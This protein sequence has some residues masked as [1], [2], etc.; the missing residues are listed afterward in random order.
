[1]GQSLHMKQFIEEQEQECDAKIQEVGLQ[2]ANE[3]RRL[4]LEKRPKQSLFRFWKATSIIGIVAMIV[5]MISSGVPTGIILFFLPILAGVG[6]SMLINYFHGKH[7][8]GIDAQIRSVYDAERRRCDEYCNQRDAAI[9][10]EEKRF[11][12]EVGVAMNKYSGSE[13]IEPL[14]LWLFSYIETKIKAAD[15]GAYVERIQ[16]EMRFSVYSTGV[17]IVEYLPHADKFQMVAEFDFFKNRYNNIEDFEDRVGFTEA[18]TKQIEFQI[19]M[20]FPEDPFAPK[21]G[22]MP[23]VII[24]Q[25]DCAACVCYD[26]ENPNYRPAIDF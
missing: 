24:E 8:D 19:N 9:R 15:R 20:T 3:V 21:E 22:V 1:M 26:V 18:L 23:S 16:A 11:Y 7:N 4:E 10:E 13:V 5:G 6:L 17:E 25:N 2:R 14:V 12:S